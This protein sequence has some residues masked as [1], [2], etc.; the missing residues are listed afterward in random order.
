MYSIVTY[1][2]LPRGW[3][4][5]LIDIY[6]HPIGKTGSF[7]WELDCLSILELKS[8]LAS[9]R[10]LDQY[11]TRVRMKMMLHYIGGGQ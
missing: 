2:V 4:M 7:T 3:V 6:D 11:G 5:G 8:G 10:V 1:Y 9:L